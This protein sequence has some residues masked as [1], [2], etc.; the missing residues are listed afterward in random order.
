M[1]MMKKMIAVVVAALVSVAAFAEES[2]WS[3]YVG[4]G[5]AGL[6]SNL[7]VHDDG[8]RKNMGGALALNGLMVNQLSG[9]SVKIDF[10]IGGATT[11]DVPDENRVSGLAGMFGLGFGYSFIHSEDT[12]LALF[13]KAGYD[14][15][16]YNGKNETIQNNKKLDEESIEITELGLGADVTFVKRI[17][18]NIHFFASVDARFPVL[19]SEDRRFS[20]K[21]AD[22]S[23]YTGINRSIT[24]NISVTPSLGVM[25]KLK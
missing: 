4:I 6:F 21:D 3:E 1:K 15:Y 18:N 7:K 11:K 5:V 19:G 12:V 24:G 17:S 20:D 9:L 14:Y 22:E 8:N 16:A 25:W 2:N 23:Y 10:D 13:A